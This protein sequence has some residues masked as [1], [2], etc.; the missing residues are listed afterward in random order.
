MKYTKHEAIFEYT[1]RYVP[2]DD[3]IFGYSP[4][5]ISI[6]L[7]MAQPPRPKAPATHPPQNPSTIN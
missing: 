6:G 7:K 5:V 4:I 3:A 2:V 1:T